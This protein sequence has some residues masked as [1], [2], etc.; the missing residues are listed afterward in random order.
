MERSFHFVDTTR[1]DKASK[2]RMRRF[3]MKGKNAGK[4]IHR[5][6]RL[7]L[8]ENHRRPPQS[9]TGS[10]ALARVTGD[11]VDKNALFTYSGALTMEYRHCL[12]TYSL[13]FK[14]APHLLKVINISCNEI[15]LGDGGTSQKALY[16]LSRTFVQVRKRLASTDALSDAT[17]GIVLSLINQEQIRK[18]HASARVHIDGLKRMIELRGG[19]DDFEGNHALLLKICK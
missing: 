15:F 4:T 3:V 13:P 6:S 8:A 11:D 10:T 7:A 16:Y 9:S 19:L 2:R 5:P 1:N 18:E 17:V 12:P 14:V